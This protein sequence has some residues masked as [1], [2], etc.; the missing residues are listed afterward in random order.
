M[1]VLKRQIVYN[2]Q[3]F[4]YQTGGL[5]GEAFDSWFFGRTMIKPSKIENNQKKP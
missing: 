5:T 3:Y 2:D 4:K 1:N